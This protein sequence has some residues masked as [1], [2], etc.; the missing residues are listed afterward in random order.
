MKIL[1]IEDEPDMRDHIVRSLQQEKYVVE[2]AEDYYSARGKTALYDY[3][4][5][6]LHSG[7]PGGSGLKF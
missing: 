1:V 7:L 4:C 6:L 5:I 3:G 2:T